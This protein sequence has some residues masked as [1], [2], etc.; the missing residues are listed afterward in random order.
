MASSSVA[1]LETDEPLS[2]EINFKIFAANLDYSSFSSFF[3]RINLCPVINVCF[4]DFYVLG[5]NNVQAGEYQPMF[6]RNL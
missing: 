1:Y 3:Y 6:R 2:Q 5:Y 4:V